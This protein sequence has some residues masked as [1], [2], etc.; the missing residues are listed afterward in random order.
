[1]DPWSIASVHGL[2]GT[3]ARVHSISSL[4]SFA[5]EVFQA[6]GELIDGASLSLDKLCLKTGQVSSAM[7]HN[8]GQTPGWKSRVL[9]LMPS[10]PVMPAFKAGARGAIRVTDCMT[11]REFRQTPHYLDTLLPIGLHFQTATEISQ[12]VK[13]PCSISW[14]RISLWP[15]ATFKELTLSRTP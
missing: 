4:E 14:L 3:L 6:I 7:S 8:V 1:V 13:R 10:H 11:Q 9:E 15:I 5:S 2:T 12:I